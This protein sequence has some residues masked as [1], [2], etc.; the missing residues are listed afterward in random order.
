L[1]YERLIRDVVGNNVAE[2]PASARAE[3]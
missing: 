2:I 3:G 1:H